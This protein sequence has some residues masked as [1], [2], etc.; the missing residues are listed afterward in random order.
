[1]NS[2]KI[3]IVIQDSEELP[4]GTGRKI[5]VLEMPVF[6]VDDKKRIEKVLEKVDRLSEMVAKTD[7]SFLNDINDKITR[8][9]RMVAER[10]SAS[11]NEINDS[12]SRL[13][14]AV[15]ERDASYAAELRDSMGR[16]FAAISESRNGTLEEVH[17]SVGKLLKS[18]AEAPD[19]QILSE[20]KDSL[21][22]VA[23]SLQVNDEKIVTFLGRTVENIENTTKMLSDIAATITLVS[24]RLNALETRTDE[25]LYVL[26]STI[27]Y[28]KGVLIDATAKINESAEGN[29]RK[30][31]AL[32]ENMN[33][34]F[35]AH[36]AILNSRLENM[37]L[38]VIEPLNDMSLRLDNMK[39][40]GEKLEKLR[41]DVS[42]IKKRTESFDSVSADLESKIEEMKALSDRYGIMVDNIST[43]NETVEK[44]AKNAGKKMDTAAKSFAT[45]MKAAEKNTAKLEKSLKKTL[46]DVRKKDTEIKGLLTDVRRVNLYLS[47]LDDAE[48]LLRIIDAKK[49]MS[50]KLRV[51]VAE[52]RRIS[53]SLEIIEDDI[54]DL[55]I[56][57]LVRKKKMNFVMIQKTLG[58]SEAKVR[59]R[60]KKLV[61]D[62]RVKKERLGRYFVYSVV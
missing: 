17:E 55:S 24:E 20:I 9:A 33:E 47:R 12:I 37:S 5:K 57:A 42:D 3:E 51:P 53:K 44:G 54:L 41:D 62:G 58:V 6:D 35:D 18:V 25:K 50:A 36:M 7:T 38:Q 23:S 27:N 1:M 60:I 43:F 29:D 16:L 21:A 4:T 34:K 61:A 26:D 39:A 2:D 14:R 15:A 49:K 56:I 30:L 13:A 46:D 59:Q 11:L 22:S 45:K 48:F 28:L 31:S 52:R 40:N 10:D 19:V 32:V 8:L